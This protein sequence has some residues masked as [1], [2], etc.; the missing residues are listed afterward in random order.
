MIAHRELGS[1]VPA[2]CHIEAVLSLYPETCQTCAAL[3]QCP[4]V[5]VGYA[6]RWGTSELVP[7]SE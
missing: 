2:G 1:L 3:E 5:A 6:K 4:G 7:F